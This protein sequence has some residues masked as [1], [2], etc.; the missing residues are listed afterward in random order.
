[1]RI[2]MFHPHSRP[3]PV[4]PSRPVELISDWKAGSEITWV[5]AGATM[6][7]PEQRVYESDRPRRLAFSWHPVTPEFGA[8]T[9]ASSEE[10]ATLAPEGRSRVAFDIEP[11]GESVKLTV[12][13]SGF[14][15]GSEIREGVSGGWPMIVASLKSLLETGE[16]L[17]FG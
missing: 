6:A 17:A 4:F 1:M 13:Q 3:D 15:V 10:V 12:T 9:G 14:P 7:H 11:M 16:P 5:Y 2:R 8:A